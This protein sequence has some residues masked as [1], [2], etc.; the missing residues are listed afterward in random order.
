MVMLMVVIVTVVVAVVTVM[1][2]TVVIVCGCVAV[3]LT[4]CLTSDVR[5]G[6]VYVGH[7]MNLFWELFQVRS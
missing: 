3:W 2:V 6:Q 4:H 5:I 7:F 1:I